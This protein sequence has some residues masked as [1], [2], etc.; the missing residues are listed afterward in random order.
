VGV[1]IPKTAQVMVTLAP[2]GTTRSTP[3]RKIISGADSAVQ[4]GVISETD[5]GK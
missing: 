2:T 3:W 5:R 4:R 1:G